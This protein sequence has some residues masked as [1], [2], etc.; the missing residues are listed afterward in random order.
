MLFRSREIALAANSRYVLYIP[1]KFVCFSPEIFIKVNR[2]GIIS[3]YPMKGTIDATL[4]HAEKTILSDYKESA[5]HYTIVDLLR[6]DLSRICTQVHVSRLRYLDR[7]H[8]SSGDILQVSSEIKGTLP[9]DY[10]LRMGDLLR[11]LLPAGSISGAPKWKTLQIIRDAE[12]EKR[13]YYCGIFGYFDG[14]E[15][16]S[17]V[18]IRFI[19]QQGDAYF[20]RSGS[21][22]TVNSNCEY[23]YNEVNQKIYLPF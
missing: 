14:K 9:D 16:D 3:T 5:E 4:P 2:E 6:S 21:G 1:D 15:L 13:G 23:E 7:L 10:R 11:Q 12:S 19:E 22:I 20:F 8:T 18:A 17:A